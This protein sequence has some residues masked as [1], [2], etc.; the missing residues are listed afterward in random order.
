MSSQAIRKY[1]RLDGGGRGGPIGS[2]P[3]RH[4]TNFIFDGVDIDPRRQRRGSNWV[5][6]RCGDAPTLILA[7]HGNDPRVSGWELRPVSP[8][9]TGRG[10]N[11]CPGGFG[12][13]NG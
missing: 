9:V 13:C 4:A 11:H 7:V 8:S 5:V 3:V 1:P 2:S 10:H 12:R 6:G